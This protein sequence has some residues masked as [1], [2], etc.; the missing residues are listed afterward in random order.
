MKQNRI[1]KFHSEK[2]GDL[3]AR[4]L[5]GEVWVAGLDAAKALGYKNTKDAIVKH[6]FPEYKRVINAKTIEQMASE[7]KGRDSHT[8]EKDPLDTTSP[9]GLLYIKEP[10]LYQLIFSSKL[11]D[12]IEFQRWVFEEV[13][14]TLRREGEYKMLWDDARDGG[15]VTRRTLTDTVKAF[16]EYLQE[17][18]E[19]DRPL[20]TWI[21]IF[22]NLVN[23]KLGITDNR[24]NLTAKQ[25]FELDTC[26]HICAKE[27][28]SGMMAGKGHHDI[29]KAC[30][31]KLTA[32]RELTA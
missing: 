23:K 1:F 31:E 8:F 14:P 18:N 21:V 28:E 15:K 19:L 5:N 3:R 27:I 16:C 22:T 7:S 25:L 20:G 9:R 32:W 24:D 4:Y 30:E 29:Y 2:F 26:E 6:V 13:L 17:R 12:A 11:P 10:G